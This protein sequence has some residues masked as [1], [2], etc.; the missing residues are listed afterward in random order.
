MKKRKRRIATGI[1]LKDVV[2]ATVWYP[3]GA[4]H[5]HKQLSKGQSINKKICRTNGPEIWANKG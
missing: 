5:S 1:Q 4:E 3:I 2:V